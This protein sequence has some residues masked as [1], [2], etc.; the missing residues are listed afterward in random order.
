[1]IGTSTSRD[2]DIGEPALGIGEPRLV[3]ALGGRA[4]ESLLHVRIAKVKMADM[5]RS[6]H[7]GE[8]QRLEKRP[9]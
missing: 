8:A 2:V 7:L 1:M 9:A 4:R 6:Q 5:P 3:D